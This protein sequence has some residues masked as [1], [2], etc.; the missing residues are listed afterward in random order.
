MTAA[1]LQAYQD[2]LFR[3]KRVEEI[4]N[5]MY[6]RGFDSPGWTAQLEELATYTQNGMKA[7]DYLL[8]RRMPVFLRMMKH[9]RVSPTISPLL[10]ER[11]TGNGSTSCSLSMSLPPEPTLFIPATPLVCSLTGLS[12]PS[13]SMTNYDTFSRV[14]DASPTP[15]PLEDFNAFG[16]TP[17][18]TGLPTMTEVM[19]QFME[20]LLTQEFCPVT[21]T[22][23]S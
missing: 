21:L 10:A 18:D 5:Q 22:E 4:Q 8:T 14:V 6:R 1:T 23:D 20:D 11:L 7:A 9:A 16:A 19:E 15:T 12:L 2:R 13:S 17:S 3:K